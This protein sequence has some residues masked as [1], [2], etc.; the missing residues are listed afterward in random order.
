MTNFGEKPF[1]SQPFGQEPFG[2]GFYGGGYLGP[3]VDG[4][5]NVV[6]GS[7]LVVTFAEELRSNRTGLQESYRLSP[8]SE[9]AFPARLISIE[10]VADVVQTGSS[11]FALPVEYA[12][13]SGSAGR[14]SLAEATTNVLDFWFTASFTIANIGDYIDI[15]NGVNAGPC[16]IVDV[17][18]STPTGGRQRVYLDRLL[19]LKDASNGYVEG[20]ADVLSTTGTSVT[21]RLNSVTSD[22]GLI[23]VLS[24][25]NRDTGKHIDFGTFALS[26]I[27]SILTYNTFQ[28]TISPGTF[29]A[30]AGQR[31]AVLARVTPKV[32]WRH[33]TAVKGLLLKT[34]KLTLEESYLFEAYSLL[35]KEGDPF[36]FRTFF[37]VNPPLG[38]ENR[39]K[40]TGVTFEPTEGT[41]FVD[42]D[43]PMLVDDDNLSN[44]LDYTITGP[45]AVTV[46]RVINDAPTRVA[47]HTSGFGAGDY[48]LAVSTNTPK[49]IAGNP[50]DPLFNTVIFTAS[51]PETDRS[52]FTDK[53]PIAKPPLTLQTGTGA[54][55]Q[56][57]NTVTLPG[58]TLTPSHVGLYVTLSGGVI[59]GGTFRIASV[60]AFNRVRLANTSFT[61]PDPSS[62]SLAWTLFDP[63]NGQIADDPSDVTVRIN[64]S[65]VTPDAVIGLLGQV[66]LNA[67]PSSSDDVKVDYSWVCN[68]TVELR[69]LNSKEFRLNS[70]NRD[71][72]YAH[73]RGQHKYRYNNVLIRPSDYNPEVPSVA[74]DQPLLRDLHYRA[75]ER[76]YTPVLNDPSLLLLNSPIHRIAYPPSERQ[77]SEQ[78][79]AYEGIGLPEAMA[80]DPW[81]RKGIGTATSA[82]GHLTVTDSSTGSF[83]TGQ[84]IF[85]TRPIDLTFLHVFAMSWRFE[86]NS[87]T[88]DGVFTGVAAGFADDRVAL[89]VGYILDGTTKKFGILKKGFGD[90]PSSL[91]AWTGGVDGSDNPTGQP[92]EV[93]WGATHSYR[94]FQ[95]RSGLIKVFLDGDS[96]ELLRVTPDELPALEELSGPFDEIQGAFF[97]SLSRPAENV[98]NWDFV[99]Y[100][101]QP[102]SPKQT[103][104]SSF[105]S[106][107]A[108]V[109]PEQD[110][111]PWTPV[112]FHGTETILSADYLLLD[113]TSATDV[114]TAS[115][116]G[117]VG[118]DYR[119]YVRFEPLLTTS[120]DLVIDAQVQ[121][122]THTHG[123]SPYGLTFAA[124]DGNRLM[125][126]A[127]FPDRATPKISY[128]GRSLPE[129]FQPFSW[130]TAG[131]AQEAMAGRILRI[132]DSSISDGR[133]YFYDDTAPT[134]SDDRVAAGG[135]D[136]I[137]E[138]RCLVRSYTVD[139]VGFAGAFAQVYD[140]SR[141]VGALFQ[142][143]SG[144]RYVTFHSDGVTLGSLA[145]FAF[146]WNDG[147][148]HTYRLV[149]ST[150]GN[151]VSLFI[152]GAFVGSLAYSSFAAPPPDV[153]GQ[154]SF[155]SSTPASSG[156][157][158]VVDWAYVNA[159]RVRSDLK[160][161][162]GIWKGADSDS[163]LG[164]HLPLKAS[165][166]DAAIAGNALGDVNASFLAE[167]VVAGDKLVVDAGA[168]RGV[169]TIA[170]VGSP[171]A[172]TILGTWPSQPSR[173]TYRIVQETD[174]TTLHKYRLSRD[175]TG[176]VVLLLDSDPD[177]IIRIGYNSLDLPESGVGIIKTLADGLPTVA[178]GSFDSENLEQS[179]WD[180]LRYGMTKSV[181]DMRIAPHHQ[182]L[183]QWNVMESPERLFTLLPHELTDFK[184]SSTGNVPKKDPDLFS[185]PSLPAWTQLNQDT[186]L[187]PATQT[188]EVRAPYPVQE[189]VSALNRPDDVLNNDGNFVT[190]D[191]SVRVRLIVPDDVLYT[192]LDVIEQATGVDDLLTP[193]DDE[194]QP[195]F[196]G[197]QYQKEVCLTYE[198]DVLP[199]NDTT[200]PTPWQLVSD[201]PGDVSASVLGG[202]LTYGTLGSKTVYRNN[203]PLP[204]HPSLVNEVRFRLRLTNDSTLGTGPTPVMFGLSAPGMTLALNFVTS[205]LG[206]RF[207][208]VIDVNNLRVL[209]S[210]SF[211]FD[212]GNF[213]TYRILR[214]P[215]HGV[216]QIFIDA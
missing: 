125:Q 101:I 114:T 156:A 6:D 45:T 152:D 185:N 19:S 155:G 74:L 143:V 49:D 43:Q 107:E 85:W 44:V 150:T 205:P 3:S 67:A 210:T 167:G 189:F 175:S 88:P 53:G 164:Y 126:V 137:L 108:N 61:L 4:P 9:G 116:V 132:T 94:I 97:G 28:I 181:T 142:E 151:L 68:P 147:E 206:E 191:G 186:P 195:N 102:T 95:D 187:V 177:P 121:L 8:A 2:F 165:G 141:S 89:V 48:T 98:S 176:S 83:P 127:F 100:L 56:T 71:L 109:L 159:W 14:G 172:L 140:S 104:A 33:T 149:K 119:G 91:S 103:A 161:Y 21:L 188:F 66:V 24:V 197:V 47:L 86:I 80:T 173:V 11:M 13:D 157:L 79:V 62:G 84:P 15:L 129:D 198:G 215:G 34:S 192:S 113:S 77:L 106:Y 46:K 179:K 60:L 55:L 30:T 39:P 65:P 25:Y 50:I 73:D 208:L 31:V 58:A 134:T 112:G 204:D 37:E 82:A 99:R 170:A 10:P 209:G 166:R 5:V 20:F 174:W 118:G 169:Y 42:F 183:N 38:S 213:H 201:T 123:P 194:C 203:T 35:T 158:S 196:G 122:L 75:Y 26:P 54:S 211:D 168:N 216:V 163:L 72:G 40:V 207:V 117:L 41:V 63:R 171:T 17:Q 1:E 29:T 22:D 160:H 51:I 115:V 184:S 139:G 32:Q 59:N 16:R 148:F 199:E 162:V 78:F 36:S 70:W 87:T 93:D 90:D 182:I 57:Y 193:F 64:G 136:Y 111:R 92:A 154:V 144:I 23:E 153:I 178:F 180:F 18:T 212:D 69:R 138:F 52:I 131:G 12:L 145:Q 202:V 105:V 110:A 76:A 124:D 130:G 190:N 27:C 135:L 146:D 200:A 133:V 128:G 214:D 120:S 81:D 7:T 96:L